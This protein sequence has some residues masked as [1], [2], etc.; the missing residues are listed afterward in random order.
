MN[1]SIDQHPKR[2]ILPKGKTIVAISIALVL[3]VGVSSL[4]FAAEKPRIAVIEFDADAASNWYS[5]WR[6]QGAGAVQE[7]L[8]T[9][10][11]KSGKFRVIEREKLAALM[12]EK[13]LALSGSLD[14]STAVKAGRLLGVEYLVTGAVTEYGTS[15]A[16]A[17]APGVRGLPSVR[18]KRRKFAAAINARLV[19]T[20]TGEIVWADDAREETKAVKVH[21]GGFGGGVDDNAQFDRVVKPVVKK[22]V[23]SLIKADF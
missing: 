7:V 13:N 4:A 12:R 22:L 6:N 21:V 11:V 17:R 10:L 1:K 5:W 8:V 18:F 23:Q 14:P 19:N 20:T 2:R 16:G 15:D 9:E 3:C